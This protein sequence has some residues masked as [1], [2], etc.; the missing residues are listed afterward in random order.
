MDRL[1]NYLLE[2]LKRSQEC[3]NI[4]SFSTKFRLLVKSNYCV[5]LLLMRMKIQSTI[6][7]CTS[8]MGKTFT[9]FAY[10]R[11]SR[12]SETGGDRIFD[13]IF[14]WPFV[15]HF[16]KHFLH[17]SQKSHLSPKISWW[18]FLVIDHFQAFKCSVSAQRGPKPMTNILNIFFNSIRKQKLLRNFFTKVLKII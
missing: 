11:G 6:K 18:P 9:M 17:F 5:L 7:N 3:G 8:R 2:K 12:T 13:E 1:S 15:R 14:E 10:T 16:P 4:A